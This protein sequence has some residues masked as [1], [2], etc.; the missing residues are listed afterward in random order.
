MVLTQK[1]SL[2]R[3]SGLMKESV[4]RCTSEFGSNARNDNFVRV[5]ESMLTSIG[6]LV[7]YF[8][9]SVKATDHPSSLWI[10]FCLQLVSAA[11][12]VLGP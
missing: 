11:I 7:S 9:W 12:P 6:L 1:R 10:T 2:V 8:D 5:F 4:G 3:R